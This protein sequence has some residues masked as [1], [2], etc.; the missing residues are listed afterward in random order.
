MSANAFDY[1]FSNDFDA[2]DAVVDTA[3]VINPPNR[4]EVNETWTPL[5]SSGHRHAITL[6]CPS[7]N[8]AAVQFRADGGDAEDWPKGLIAALEDVDLSRL[9][10][11]GTVGDLVLI[12]AMTQPQQRLVLA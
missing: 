8:A 9:E 4:V 7:G 2:P 5:G 12:G 1:G 6:E 11:K 3:P 10:V